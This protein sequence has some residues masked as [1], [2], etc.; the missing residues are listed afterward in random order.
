MWNEIIASVVGTGLLGGSYFGLYKLGWY[1]SRKEQENKL[2]CKIKEI[3][4][5][6]MNDELIEYKNLLQEHL[7]KLN[8]HNIEWKKNK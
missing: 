7:I 4:S 2:K 1:I 3:E 5:F 6:E 8:N